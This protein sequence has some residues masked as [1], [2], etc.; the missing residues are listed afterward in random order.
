[1]TE[2]LP[3]SAHGGQGH[4]RQE[5][6]PVTS[7]GFPP[8]P[9]RK[10]VIVQCCYREQDR[11]TA[12]DTSCKEA[13]VLDDLLQKFDFDPRNVHVLTDLKIGREQA[14]LHNVHAQLRWLV[15]RAQAGD[16]LV[17]AFFGRG[18][19]MPDPDSES[20]IGMEDCLCLSEFDP[21]EK[22]GLDSTLEGVAAFHFCS[23]RPQDFSWGRAAS[24]GGP[25]GFFVPSLIEIFRRT[26]ELVR[27]RIQ[28]T[29]PS[30]LP[31]IP[32]LPFLTFS[33]PPHECPF[34][35]SP[36]GGHLKD[37]PPLPPDPLLRVLTESSTGPPRNEAE[38]AALSAVPGALFN[39]RDCLRRVPLVLLQLVC[40]LP[41]R[42]PAAAQRHR[43]GRGQT[44]PDGSAN[45]KGYAEEDEGIEGVHLTLEEK[46]K[47]GIHR[48]EEEEGGG[49]KQPGVEVGIEG[50]MNVV[51]ECLLP[52]LDDLFPPSIF[53]LAEKAA[54]KPAWTLE[55]KVEED[56]RKKQEQDERVAERT[57][58]LPLLSHK[59][60]GSFSDGKKVL[61]ESSTGPP[62]NEAERA[63]L[64]AVPGALFN[65]R[66]CLRRV[67]LVLLQLVCR[68]PRRQPAAAQRHRPGRGQ[69]SP[70]GSANSK[71]YAEEDEGIE[72]VHLTLEE[73]RKEGIHRREE[74][75]GGGEKQPGVE[76][77]IEGL[78]N[79]VAECLLPPLDDLFPPSIFQLAEKAAGKPA[80]TLE[81]KV[82]EDERKKQE[83]DERVAERTIELPLLS[84][85]LPGS[86]SDG[87]KSFTKAVRPQTVSSL[88]P[89][90]GA[91][92]LPPHVLPAPRFF[93]GNP[94][95]KQGLPIF[96]SSLCPQENKDHKVSDDPHS[97]VLEPSSCPGGFR[98]SLG[99]SC[100]LRLT[101]SLSGSLH[102]QILQLGILG[103]TRT[104]KHTRP[105][106]LYGFFGQDSVGKRVR[107][108]WVQVCLLQPRS[109][110]E[111]LSRGEAPLCSGPRTRSLMSTDAAEVYMEGLRDS[112][113]C[114]EMH[115][116]REWAEGER[117]LQREERKVREE[118]RWK[119]KMRVADDF[120]RQFRKLEMKAVKA[121]ERSQAGQAAP[122]NLPREM[123]KFQVR[124]IPEIQTLLPLAFAEAA[125]LR[126]L[127]VGP[128]G[129]LFAPIFEHTPSNLH[130][131]IMLPS[132]EALAKRQATVLLS[133]ERVH[134]SVNEANRRIRDRQLNIFSQYRL[135]KAL[136]VGPLK[137]QCDAY[138]QTDERAF[139]FGSRHSVCVPPCLRVREYFLDP[140]RQVCLPQP[141]WPKH[142]NGPPAF[143]FP[144]GRRLLAEKSQD[145]SYREAAAGVALAGLRGDAC[146]SVS[147]S[148]PEYQYACLEGLQRS[149]LPCRRTEEALP[150]DELDR[151]AEWLAGAGEPAWH[152]SD[153]LDGCGW[154]GKRR[155]RPVLGELSSS[156]VPPVQ[157]LG[158]MDEEDE[159]LLKAAAAV[160]E[161]HWKAESSQTHKKGRGELFYTLFS[162]SPDNMSVQKM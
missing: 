140:R 143:A 11:D 78:M 58:E 64:S 99:V 132:C 13:E 55:V 8:A 94:N 26:V 136:R 62:R 37:P 134:R 146:P 51:A 60:P 90:S 88:S 68:L 48:R 84:H 36:L 109:F 66:D 149:V 21:D 74:E 47:E 31:F 12:L 137:S 108:F 106:D 123:S 30:T 103:E 86:F 49:E 101:A 144:Y 122:V 129:P 133:L 124:F 2:A 28:Q 73:K 14:T 83:Q 19:L 39:L 131:A 82:E 150:R 92:S 56:E 110:D 20:L 162:K 156:T 72:G 93:T 5:Q 70:D 10:A 1:M 104:R 45:S 59:L 157:H 159:I 33:S 118:T 147:V 97:L 67:P 76:V 41:R 22:L 16:V 116:L 79:V 160:V 121:I 119:E 142:W 75:E 126:T 115:A 145:L 135:A 63:A 27:L 127:F 153:C 4:E 85:K 9:S 96:P 141:D 25:G 43:P 105:G 44:S 138:I 113:V 107:S 17:F 111:C 35:E 18:V 71:G 77:G 42:Q 65:L 3:P 23:C 89:A 52:P 38:R 34:L 53:Q 69:T 81:V 120:E 130:S 40:R 155:E 128:S 114:A 139:P 154:T 102:L 91:S 98:S 24:S 100:R 50:L 29:D 7:S 15:D 61:T 57:I 80:W 32:P 46:R 95:N 112:R 148:S 54:G 152:R 6:F 87:K 151:R 158:E 161:T 125:P 117:R